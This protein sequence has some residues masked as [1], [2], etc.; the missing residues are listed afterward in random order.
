MKKILSSLS[1][2][3]FLMLYAFTGTRV[4]T[5]SG[6]IRSAADG[7]PVPRVSVKVKNTNISA[8]SAIDGKYTIKV[9]EKKS[10]L[11]FACIG[12]KKKEVALS[13]RKK[14]D[15][16]L[17]VNNDQLN[18]VVIVG[19]GTQ[20]KTLITGSGSSPIMIRGAS[21]GMMIRGI[22]RDE[23]YN[24]ESYAAINE[25]R[26]MGTKENPLSTFGIDVDG[27]SYSNIR[28]FINEGK[29]PPVDAVRIEEMINYFDYEYPQPTGDHPFSVNTEISTAPWNSN[30]RLLRIGLQGKKTDTKELPPSN[31]VFL[32]D[33]SGSMF[34]YNKLPLVKASLEMLVDQLRKTD[35]VAIVTYAGHAG[36]VLPS[37]QGD[38]KLTIKNAIDQ[39]AAGGSTAGGEGIK[40]AYAIAEK[41]FIKGGTNRVILATDGDFNV[42]VSSD[43]EMQRLI[44]EKRK[45]GVFLS[46]LGY[47]MGNYKDSKMETLADKGNG[48]YAYIDNISEARRVLV[49]EFGGTLFT[50]A[51]DVKLQIEFNPSKVQAYRL[52]GY[53]NRLLNKEDFNNDQ[54]DAG[55]LGAGHRVTALYEIIPAGVKSKFTDSVDKLKYQ[56]NE[57]PNLSSNGDELL[58]IKLRYKKPDE[59]RSRLIEKP[60]VDHKTPWSATSDDFR[61]ASAVAGYGMLLRKS[62]FSQQA[63]FAN[64]AEIA[65]SALGKDPEGYRAEFLRIVK[66]SALVAKDL[67]SATEN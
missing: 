6:T 45:G 29:L 57:A 20:K 28:R 13:G 51:K 31:L 1:V 59:D 44:E 54:K 66:S 53:E 35:K 10:V 34:S 4:Y 56:K 21:S 25:N 48:N 11:V 63:T 55:D 61:F 22:A 64:L 19:H 43:G 5:I 17:E 23:D 15:V 3:V 2:L 50:I 8:T 16:T 24:T 18:E 32:I 41:N 37:T 62:E 52:I 14:M 42:G 60:V 49:K 12:F 65:Q 40:A 39:L 36:E 33:V 30:H 7:L 9:P 47:G 46:V 58:T 67:L 38:K 26:F 27:A